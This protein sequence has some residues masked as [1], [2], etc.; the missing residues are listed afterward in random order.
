LPVKEFR[1]Q[2]N[3]PAMITHLYDFI[4]EFLWI[5]RIKLEKIVEENFDKL[6]I[7]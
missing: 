3:T 4:S 7:N 6:Y 1:G 5:D 2:L